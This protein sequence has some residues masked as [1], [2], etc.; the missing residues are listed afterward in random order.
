M[1]P[2]SVRVSI[3]EPGVIL[4]PIWHKRN[5]PLPDG[6]EYG[7]A[8]RRL[9]R[10]FGSQM[11]DGTLPD[12]V[13]SAIYDAATRTDLPLR[14]PVGADAE[15]LAAGRNK[16]SADEWVSLY[17]EPDEDAFVARAEKAFGV[18]TLNAPS[19]NARRHRAAPAR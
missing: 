3:I 8:M 5:V 13:A 14:L 7:F 16:M 9:M 15:V 2:F 19:L 12:A 4:T 1:R 10:V 18:D 6:H 17:S 11:E